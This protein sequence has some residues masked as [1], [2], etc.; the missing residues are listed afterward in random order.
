[1]FPQDV[2]LEPNRS[3]IYNMV[4][5][6]LG[7]VTIVGVGA[8]VHSLVAGHEHTFG[9]SREVPWGILIAAYIFFVVTS[10]GLCIVSSMSSDL[11][12]LK[13][14]PNVLFFFQ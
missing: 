5:Y 9:V 11:K 1:M 13:P 2:G 4:I 10:T 14:S 12:I 8:G 7:F 3:S 6:F